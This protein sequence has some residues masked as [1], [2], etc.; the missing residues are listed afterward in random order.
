MKA[1]VMREISALPH[2]SI[3]YFAHLI[4]ASLPA[5]SLTA[6]NYA[7]DTPGVSTRTC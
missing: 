5:S 4:E 3:F 6:A 7:S 2:R 1:A